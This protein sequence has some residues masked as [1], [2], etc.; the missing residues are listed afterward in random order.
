MIN[1]KTKLSQVPQA[2]SLFRFMINKPQ[3]I[4]YTTIL[5]CCFSWASC[6]HKTKHYTHQQ[7]KEYN[8]NLVKANK[9]LVSQD[10]EAIEKY[11]SRHNWKMNKTETGL[12]YEITKQGAGQNVESGKTVHLRYQLNLLNGTSCYNSDSLGLK[13]FKVGQGGVESG[14]EEAVLL[15]KEGD[16]ARFILPPHLAYGLLGDENKIPPRSTIVYNVE[17]INLT[18]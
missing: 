6:K 5:L 8:E 17:L 16:A 15:L 18:Q 12:W 3:L 1:S 4:F 2:L 13:I 11:V 14:L 10:Q 9:E 7:I